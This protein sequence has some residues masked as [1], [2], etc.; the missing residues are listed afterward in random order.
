MKK[1][2]LLVLI[3]FL[4]LVKTSVFAGTQSISVNAKA[5]IPTILELKIEETGQSELRFG[6]IQPSA[7]QT[8]EAG[9]VVVRIHV[10]SNIGETYQ[11][12]QAMSNTLENTQGAQMGPENL[13]FKTKAV[14]STGTVISSPTPVTKSPQTIFVSDAKGTSDTIQA[15]YMLTV[16]ASQAP[17]DYSAILTYTVSSL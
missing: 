16:P 13:K 5:D 6:N 14:L 11:V 4:S 17:G 8:I 7:I 12:T 15:E 9:P 10:T 1:I 2:L 3:A